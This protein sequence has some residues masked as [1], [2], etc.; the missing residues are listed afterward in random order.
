MSLSTAQ[1]E[2]YSRQLIL[3]EWSA[4][5]QER[6]CSMTA[7][8]PAECPILALYLSGLGMKLTDNNSADVLVQWL[9]K[10]QPQNAPI[11]LSCSRSGEELRVTLRRSESTETYQFCT[12]ARQAFADELA[13]AGAA[14]L[15]AQALASSG[16]G[17]PLD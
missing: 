11:L 2:R 13:Q 4:E 3:P 15:V 5:L 14:A 9:D 17:Q 6:I 10:P 7:A 1:I 12:G 16:T 8:V